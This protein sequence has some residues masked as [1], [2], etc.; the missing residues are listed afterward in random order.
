M[1]SPPRRSCACRCAGWMRQRTLRQW[2][3][4]QCADRCCHYDDAG[5]DTQPCNGRGGGDADGN[6][7]GRIPAGVR[8]GNLLRWD[9]DAGVA[10]DAGCGGGDTVGDDIRGGFD[11]YV[12]GGVQRRRRPCDQYLRVNGPFGERGGR[13]CV[14]RRSCGVQLCEPESN[15][16]GLWRGGGLRHELSDEPSLPCGDLQGIVRPDCGI[17]IELFASAEQLSRRRDGLRH[18]YADDRCGGEC[19]QW[20]SADAADVFVVAIGGLEEQWGR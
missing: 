12:E 18:G 20:L 13:A 11:A 14:D 3:R 4:Y 2:H 1:P 8:D 16:C 17:G 19:G 5:G 7:R 9:G 6:G 10:C 15:H